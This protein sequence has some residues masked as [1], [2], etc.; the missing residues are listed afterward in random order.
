MRNLYQSPLIRVLLV[1]FIAGALL[2]NV[3]APAQAAVIINN[4]NITKDQT[5]DDDVLI[6]GDIVTVDGTVNGLLGVVGNKVTIN[7]TI[8]GDA[9]LLGNYITIGETAKITGNLF[10]GGSVLEVR[11]SVD[12]SVFG[13]A[14]TMVVTGTSKIGRNMFYGGFSL[15]V[16]T[17]A[18]IPRD[19]FFGGYQ[20]LL[21]GDV[22]RNLSVGSGAAE[23]NGKVGQDAI[24]E[25]GSPDEQTPP[26]QLFMPQQQP[27]MATPVP[28]GLRI[29]KDASIGGKLTYT[30]PKEQAGAIKAQPSGGV[31]YQTPVPETQANDKNQPVQEPSWEVRFPILGWLRNFIGELL[32]LIVIGLLA[33]RFVPG[34]LQ[35]VSATVSA[36]P[37]PE[38]GKGLVAV[39]AVYL[40]AFLSAIL[41]I[42]V[43]LLLRLLSLSSLSSVLW[44]LGF[45]AMTALLAIFSFLL[46]YGSKIVVAYLIGSLLFEKIAPQANAKWWG[47]ILGIVILALVNT[48]PVIGFL[49]NLVICLVGIGAII[50]ELRAWR[51]TQQ[52]QPAL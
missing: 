5:I 10:T 28:A 29:A 46:V 49:V 14:H 39:L 6:N 52:L 1:L 25:I 42:L 7:G 4:G 36:K 17:G 40:G 31:V 11:G 19:L 47:I 33:V 32:S 35:K 50:T 41:L 45:A 34:A 8:N 51:K 2:F 3:A 48:I 44:S 24:I 18:R 15:E 37:L 21:N 27:G 22:D 20:L 30:S 26:F 12:G 16:K 38:A 43:G 9:V 13:G 23:I